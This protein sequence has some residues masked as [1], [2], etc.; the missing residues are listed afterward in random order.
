MIGQILG[1]MEVLGIIG[2][3]LHYTKI[4]VASVGI[5]ILFWCF[6]LPGI[7]LLLIILRNRK[8]KGK[9]RKHR[10]KKCIT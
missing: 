10:G 7:L 4:E 2:L 3:F 9:E 1:A 6:I 5:L 8:I